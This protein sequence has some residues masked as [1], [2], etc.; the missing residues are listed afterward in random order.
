MSD[1]QRL[2]LLEERIYTLLCG[3]G[4]LMRAEVDEV[5]AL[6]SRVGETWDAACQRWMPLELED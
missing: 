4:Y 5:D 6:R 1:R 3:G 2:Q